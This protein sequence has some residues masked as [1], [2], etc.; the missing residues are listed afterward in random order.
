MPMVLPG[1]LVEM[2][3]QLEEH[4]QQQIVVMD[5]E[6]GAEPLPMALKA[7]AA[8]IVRERIAKN[9]LA[10][11]PLA[12]LAQTLRMSAPKECDDSFWANL[13]RPSELASLSI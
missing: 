3:K 4:R 11:H 5:R 2:A 8:W 7:G 6:H 12:G 9:Q 1:P 13:N 10:L